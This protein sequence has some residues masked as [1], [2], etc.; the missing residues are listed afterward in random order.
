MKSGISVGD[1]M[2]RNFVY[3][4]PET[5]LKECAKTLVKKRV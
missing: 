3:V 1:L 5:N 4:S 2:T